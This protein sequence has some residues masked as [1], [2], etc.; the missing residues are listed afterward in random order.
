M[1]SCF[2]Y[3]L[4]YDQLAQGGKTL[5]QFERV[6]KTISQEYTKN[7]KGPD[8]FGVTIFVFSIVGNVSKI[9]PILGTTN[10]RRNRNPSASV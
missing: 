8:R 9:R 10:L 6:G 1:P 2:R 4:W 3:P 5:W 7:C